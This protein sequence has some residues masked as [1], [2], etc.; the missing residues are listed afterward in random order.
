MKNP[1]S[2][3]SLTHR[4]YW[5]RHWEEAIG[6]LERIWKEDGLL[7]VIIGKITLILPPELEE[8]LE[9]KVGQRISIL[10]TDVL[11]KEFL[12]RVLSEKDDSGV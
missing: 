4:C 3:K 10:H 12:I 11:K 2:G 7:K 6:Q 5:L 1:E 8:K 9:N